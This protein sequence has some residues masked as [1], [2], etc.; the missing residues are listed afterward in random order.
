MTSPGIEVIKGVLELVHWLRLLHIVRQ[1]V[2]P[3]NHY[4]TELVLP[5]LLGTVCWWN[6]IEVA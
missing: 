6:N 1:T 3:V 5:K 2:P 4:L